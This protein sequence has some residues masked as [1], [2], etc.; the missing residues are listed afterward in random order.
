MTQPERE[1]VRVILQVAKVG[2]WPHGTCPRCRCAQSR[3]H[4]C[5][6]PVK[7]AYKLLSRVLGQPEPGLEDDDL[8][9]ESAV[10][11]LARTS[12]QEERRSILWATVEAAMQLGA[13]S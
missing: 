3:G 5:S 11:K 10:A 12:E 7:R 1:A 2:E 13:R 4:K 8:I 6:C 9:V